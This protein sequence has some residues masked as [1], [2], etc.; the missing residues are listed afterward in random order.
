MTVA[1]K[2]ELCG[3]IISDLFS[4]EGCPKLKMLKSMYFHIT[5]TQYPCSILWQNIC[6]IL[7]YEF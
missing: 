6:Y 7:V 1:V 3:H 4:R 2:Q 5:C